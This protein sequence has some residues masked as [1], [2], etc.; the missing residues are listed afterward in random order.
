MIPSRTAS[1]GW[2]AVGSVVD[3]GEIGP[4]YNIH[5]A[6]LHTYFVRNGSGNADVLVHNDSGTVTTGKSAQ[7][8]RSNLYNSSQT[9][10]SGAT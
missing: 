7:L 5:V 4:V 9:R 2:I 6:G 8:P 10:C 3:K 1:G